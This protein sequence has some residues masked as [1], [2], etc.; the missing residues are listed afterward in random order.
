MD[1]AITLVDYH[2]D[3]KI[4]QNH[5]MVVRRSKDFFLDTENKEKDK[6]HETSKN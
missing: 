2:G 3:S 1:S 4:P 6:K 5:K